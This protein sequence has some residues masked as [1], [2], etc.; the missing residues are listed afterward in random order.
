MRNNE[1][2]EQ[3]ASALAECPS[4]VDEILLAL[5]VYQVRSLKKRYNGSTFG[6]FD[7]ATD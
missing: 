2:L 6:Y 1:S 5:R 4:Q 3:L 7:V